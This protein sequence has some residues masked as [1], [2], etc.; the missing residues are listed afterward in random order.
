MGFGLIRYT[1]ARRSS[2]DRLSII[3]C[4]E[5][6]NYRLAADNRGRDFQRHHERRRGRAAEIRTSETQRHQVGQ[7]KTL[8]FRSH[9]WSENNIRNSHVDK[10]KYA[11]VWENRPFLH[12][13]HLSSIVWSF[14]FFHFLRLFTIDEKI[15]NNAIVTIHRCFHFFAHTHFSVI[16]ISLQIK[17]PFFL[18]FS[19]TT[20]I[21][22]TNL[23]DLVKINKRNWL[24]GRSLKEPDNCQK[25][26]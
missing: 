12:T 6:I 24:Q 8:F 13:W 10:Y 23:T 9:T 16:L 4:H 18:F 17:R 19:L 2:K 21:Q 25:N 20:F 1:G 5:P 15:I 7:R 26:I 3:V 11:H 22:L 14:Q